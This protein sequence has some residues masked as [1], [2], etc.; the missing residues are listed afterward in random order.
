MSKKKY[1]Y[2]E[3][4]LVILL[5]VCWLLVYFNFSSLIFVVACTVT[6]AFNRR[7]KNNL[8]LLTIF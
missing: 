8:F 1:V 4:M 6:V 3:M 7:K 5:P 2:I